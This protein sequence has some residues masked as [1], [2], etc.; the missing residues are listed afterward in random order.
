VTIPIQGLP[1]SDGALTVSHTR[2]DETH[3]NAFTAW[4]AMGSPQSPDAA[5][6]K[7]LE[8]ASQLAMLPAPQGIAVENGRTAVTLDLPRQSISLLTFEAV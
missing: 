3:G 1:W 5:Q 7:Q 8:Q 6:Y 2:I 4:K